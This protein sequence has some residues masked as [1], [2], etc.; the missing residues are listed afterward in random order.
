VNANILLLY[1]SDEA[2]NRAA[3]GE[4]NAAG[5][6]VVETGANGVTRAG[7]SESGE[8]DRDV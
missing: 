7:G 3:K 6:E 8:A 4:G 5:F 1:R 2:Y